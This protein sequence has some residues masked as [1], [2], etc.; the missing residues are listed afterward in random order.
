MMLQRIILQ[1]EKSQC[2]HAKSVWRMKKS[3]SGLREG[4]TGVSCFTLGEAIG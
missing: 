1:M 2:S 3:A 4:R